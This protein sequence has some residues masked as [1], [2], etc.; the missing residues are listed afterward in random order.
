MGELGVS[1]TR[2]LLWVRSRRHRG[3]GLSVRPGSRSPRPRP[4]AA[5][6]PLGMGWVGPAGGQSA[7]LGWD[8]QPRLS[9]GTGTPLARPAAREVPGRPWAAGLSG[10]G[11]ERTTWGA[12]GGPVLPLD[13]HSVPHG[14]ARST[15][16]GENGEAKISLCPSVIHTGA[17]QTNQTLMETIYFLDSIDRR[18]C[19]RGNFWGEG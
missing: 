12:E 4:E 1:A 8:S 9:G 2:W 14:C 15:H 17:A 19:H 10:S 18:T 5:S 7:A 3:D 6:W 11:C 16:V 13:S